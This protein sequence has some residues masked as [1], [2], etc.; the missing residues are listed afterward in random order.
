MKKLNKIKSGFF[1]RQIG[2]AKL[3]L[4]TGSALYKNRDQGIKDQLK[5][6]I[7][8]Y[9]SDIADELNVMKGSFMK[10]G[11]M[12]SLL[13][14]SF[15]PE[16]AHKILK[17]LENK[18]SFLEWE[19]I[20]KQI[21]TAW[22]DELEINQE[23]L[24]AASLGQVHLFTE[25]QKDYAMKIQYRGVRKAIK[26]DVKALKLFMNALN[27]LPK[28]IDLNQVYKE[29]EEMLT[30]E[31]DYLHEVK[32][33]EK[34]E[35]KLIPF[36]IFKVPKVNHKFSNED[37]ITTEYLEGHSLHDLESLNLSEEQRNHLGREFMRLLFL[38]LFVFEEIQTDAHFGNY[39]LIT[40]PEL[41]WGLLDFGAT[42]VPGKDFIKHYQELVILLS[43]KD[44][45]AFIDKL[46]EMGYISKEKASDLD[47]FWEYANIIGAPFYEEVY[48]WG[49]TDLSIQIYEYIPKIIKS[50]S[51]GNPPSDSVFIDRKIAGVYFILQKL[52]ARFD[53]NQLLNEVLLYKTQEQSK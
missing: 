53:V 11:Q 32:N 6:S 30:E 28:E 20:K 40:E 39:L 17:S 51:V 26:N 7:E 29:I 48:D 8:K 43:K 16:E 13:G 21:P 47:L 18:S 49:K 36:P 33:T 24:A 46:K 15:L 4:K 45:E 12:L 3:A 22:L 19:Q 38:E 31:T 5:N 9:A 1:S 42:K 41:R 23:P 10:A 35:Q 50:I 14:G 2:I 52:K 44:R 27:L 34:F 37:I 25:D